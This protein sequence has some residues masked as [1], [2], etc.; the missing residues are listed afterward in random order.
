MLWFTGLQGFRADPVKVR[1]PLQ[2]V[3]CH[4]SGAIQAP[5]DI[6]TRSSWCDAWAQAKTVPMPPLPRT[7]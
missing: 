3:S 5:E 4:R 1:S 7:E 6:L 2:V